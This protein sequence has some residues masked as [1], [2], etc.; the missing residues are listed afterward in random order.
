MAII[1]QY[2]WE[3]YCGTVAAVVGSGSEGTREKAVLA[4]DAVLKSWLDDGIKR[5]SASIEGTAFDEV[6]L[7]KLGMTE[8][9][10]IGEWVWRDGV[11][12]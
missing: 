6:E 11:W 4:A 10:Q 3:V 5:L 8:T 12:Q 2:D 1:E 7:E 9:K